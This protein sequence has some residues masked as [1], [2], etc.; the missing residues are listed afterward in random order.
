MRRKMKAPSQRRAASPEDY[1]QFAEE[2]VRRCLAMPASHTH[3]RAVQI[4]LA[5][6][7]DKLAEQTEERR[8][9]HQASAAA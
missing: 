3:S 8:K 6:A 9:Q 4:I 5:R 7:W 2:S 1:R